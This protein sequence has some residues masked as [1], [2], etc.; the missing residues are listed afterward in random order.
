MSVT[1]YKIGDRNCSFNCL[2]LIKDFHTT[3][4]KMKDLLRRARV[5]VRTSNM[6]V[7]RRRL[8][9]YVTKFST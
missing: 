4:K 2:A 8:V 1:L 6:E 5:V 3:A 9:D 7:L